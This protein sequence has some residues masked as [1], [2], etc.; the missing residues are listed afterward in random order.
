MDNF[1]GKKIHQTGKQIWYKEGKIHR[2]GD[3]PAIIWV[4]GAKE[5][6]KEGKCHR[7]GNL[8]AIIR[9][10]G[11]QYWF[12]EGKIHRDG[13]LPACIRLDGTQLWFKEGKL[14]R[15]G[16][17]KPLSK[18]QELPACIWLSGIQKWF[19]DDKL[20][21]VL[22]PA[23]LGPAIVNE[24]FLYGKEYS[25]DKW[26]LIVTQTERVILAEW[27]SERMRWRNKVIDDTSET[28]FIEHTERKGN[29][30]L[31]MLGKVPRAYLAEILKQLSPIRL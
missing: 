28:E 6:Y 24:Y 22:G 14:H 21:R 15:D 18:A 12:K 3:L 17:A 8:P 16:C 11:S 30:L 26:L 27:W 29:D 23:V 20:H 1:T 5:W 13:D 9:A 2:D 4:H 7:D 19:K 10:D 31:K 25:R